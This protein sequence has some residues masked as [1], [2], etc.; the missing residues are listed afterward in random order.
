M[1]G[2][3]SQGQFSVT[4]SVTSGADSQSVKYVLLDIWTS[5]KACTHWKIKDHSCKPGHKLELGPKN[6]ICNGLLSIYYYVQCNVK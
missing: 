2:R 5:C 4:M 1:S 6:K 3:D